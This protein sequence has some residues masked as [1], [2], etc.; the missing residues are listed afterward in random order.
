MTG[1]WLLLAALWLSLAVNVFQAVS[2]ARLQ[3]EKKTCAST[4]SAYLAARAKQS[5]V[6]PLPTKGKVQA[7]LLLRLDDCPGC[8][9][10]VSTFH[11][12]CR[13]WQVPCRIEVLGGSSE[14]AGEL[15]RR[16]DLTVPVIGVGELDHNQ[17][18]CTPEVRLEHLGEKLLQECVPPGPLEQTL[19]GWRLVDALVARVE[20]SGDGG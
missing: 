3:R 17:P 18:S 16:F 14:Q 4:L 6:A 13:D 2:I 15:G 1:R 10:F 5:L 12:V 19:L 11:G 7:R 8:V 9:D 20:V